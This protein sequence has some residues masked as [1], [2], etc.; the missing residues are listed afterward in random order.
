MTDPDT[1]RLA[2]GWYPAPQPRDDRPFDETSWARPLT[3]PSAGAHPPAPPSSAGVAGPTS[4]GLATASVVLGAVSLVLNVLLV[5]T[6]LGIVFG[7]V[8]LTRARTR[9]SVGQA[10]SIIG[11][12]LA[13]LG[14]LAF[15]IEAAIAIP[16]YLSV[17]DHAKVA[18]IESSMT[19]QAAKQGV[20]L[21]DVVCPASA[22]VE[23]GS[24]FSCTAATAAGVGVVL[25]VSVTD[26]RGDFT[27]TA[28]RSQ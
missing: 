9:G 4:N 18:M 10:R 27:F 24:T 12:V 15:G 13:S 17:Q 26:A 11:I 14:V 8:G 25:R 23:P 5:P 3:R 16:V 20:V 2:P 19:T 1:T 7:V 21:D 6:I 28:A 22:A